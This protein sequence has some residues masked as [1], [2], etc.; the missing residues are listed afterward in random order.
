MGEMTVVSM[1]LSRCSSG[2][3]VLQVEDAHSGDLMLKVDMTT[4]ELG[5]LITGL[6]G[7]KGSAEVFTDANIARE[8]TIMR[9]TC[10]KVSR[11]EQ[12]KCVEDDF[13]SRFAPDGWEIQSDGTSSQQDGVDHGYV[14]KRY[15]RVQDV[16]NVDRYY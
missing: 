11:N 9:V 10:P 13:G 3:V 8:R 15:E 1:G 12:L 6:H 4:E 16:S 14:I 5:L 2:K 7:V